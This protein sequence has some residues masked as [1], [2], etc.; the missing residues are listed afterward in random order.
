MDRSVVCL[1][2]RGVAVD[3]HR[4]G[5]VCSVFCQTR[6]RVAEMCWVVY[7]DEAEEKAA[8]GDERGV[9][10]EHVEL[11]RAEAGARNLERPRILGQLGGLGGWKWSF[12]G[13]GYARNSK[14]NKRDDD[15]DSN[16]PSKKL[17]AATPRVDQCQQRRVGS[18][19]G[20][21]FTGQNEKTGV[22][23]GSS[24]KF[25]QATVHLSH[26]HFMWLAGLSAVNGL[27]WSGLMS[28]QCIFG[29]KLKKKRGQSFQGIQLHFDAFLAFHPPRPSIP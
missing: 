18:A 11:D 27:A 6:A 16:G 22:Q 13:N 10:R 9:L 15:D 23:G 14:F 24:S 7:C 4:R 1:S 17:D 8:A 19:V 26:R 21:N 2:H 20:T 29:S 25:T 28:I 3:R 5:E 12:G